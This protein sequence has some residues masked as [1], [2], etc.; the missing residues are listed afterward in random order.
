M[1]G[2]EKN[3]HFR[4]H[5][6]FWPKNVLA[7]SSVNQEKAIKIVISAEIAQNQNDT[8]F[9]KKRCFLTWVK[10]WVLLTVFLKR[11]VLLK[12]YFYSVFREAQQLQYKHCM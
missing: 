11:C 3:A 4:A 7:Q 1:S 2:R 8:F 9:G 12:H 10:K 6:L 5:Y